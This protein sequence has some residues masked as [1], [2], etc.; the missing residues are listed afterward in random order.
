ITKAR[1][2]KPA[3]QRALEQRA[4]HTIFAMKDV[5]I[6]NFCIRDSIYICRH[7]IC[8]SRLKQEPMQCMKCRCWGH[9]AN[10]CAA[11]IDTCGTRRGEDRM[12]DCTSKD[13]TYCISCK[14]SSHTS[15]DRECPEFQR[16]CTQ[17]DENF[18]ENNLPYFPTGE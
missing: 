15:W 9:Y 16:R 11:R 12:K 13:K 5:N 6:T 17:Y 18:P 10:G 14:S 7:K 4:A 1:W 3:N 8:P 2:I